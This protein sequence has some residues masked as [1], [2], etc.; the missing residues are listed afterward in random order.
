MRKVKNEVTGEMEVQFSA[1]LIA[2]LSETTLKNSNG[3]E[4]K[5]ASIK[6]TPAPSI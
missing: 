6:P 3:K 1:E 5:I 2:P 4:Y